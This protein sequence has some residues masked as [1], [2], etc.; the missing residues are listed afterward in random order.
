LI[1]KFTNKTPVCQYNP[2]PIDDPLSLSMTMAPENDK[3]AQSI[4]VSFDEVGPI[5]QLSDWQ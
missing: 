5:L 3:Y 1:A 4:Y 2:S